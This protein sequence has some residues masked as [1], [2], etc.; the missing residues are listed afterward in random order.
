MRLLRFG[1]FILITLTFS[2]GN[3]SAAFFAHYFALVT[4]AGVVAK[5]SGVQSAAKPAVGTYDITFNNS[6]DACAIVATVSQF[7]PAYATARKTAVDTTA[8]ISVY[9]KSGVKVDLPFHVIVSC[10][11]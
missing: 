4:A 6:L 2:A 10:A 8:R 9:N 11:P 7:T 1:C 3:V 5:S